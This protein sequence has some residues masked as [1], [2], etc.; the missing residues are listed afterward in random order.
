MTMAMEYIHVQ[1]THEDVL[2]Y[3]NLL[4]PQGKV[5]SCIE[6]HNI[7]PASMYVE[8]KH[9]PKSKISD[10][11]KNTYQQLRPKCWQ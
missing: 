10:Y 7:P 5:Q 8:C 11:N 4:C 2:A 3:V 9:H 1:T 6:A